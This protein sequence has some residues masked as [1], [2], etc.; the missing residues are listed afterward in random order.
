MERPFEG[1]ILSDAQRSLIRRRAIGTDLLSDVES[2]LECIERL[3]TVCDELAEDA[4]EDD[5][6]GRFEHPDAE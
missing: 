2:L 4:G 5:W 3:E 6:R 1:E